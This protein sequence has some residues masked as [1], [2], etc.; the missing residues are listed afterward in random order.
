MSEELS[1]AIFALAQDC[2]S[3]AGIVPTKVGEHANHDSAQSHFNEVNELCDQLE[4]LAAQALKRHVTR[5]E[6]AGVRARLEA[7]KA[8]PGGPTYA[9]LQSAFSR[10]G[11][12]WS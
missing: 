9:S 5:T 1:A 4:N 11:P 10:Q 2:R 8:F 12:P 7:I 3:G 6:F